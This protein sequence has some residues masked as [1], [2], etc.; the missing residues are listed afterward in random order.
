[1]KGLQHRTIPGDLQH[2]G[3][4][5]QAL[6]ELLEPPSVKDLR[7]GVNQ[8]PLD[9]IGQIDVPSQERV[10]TVLRGVQAD[11]GFV[12]ERWDA[13]QEYV[14]EARG[15]P[16]GHP[17]NRY[18]T[19]I[20]TANFRRAEDIFQLSGNLGMHE[21]VALHEVELS[22]LILSGPLPPPKGRMVDVLKVCG[23]RPF[24]LGL[25]EDCLTAFGDLYSSADD[26]HRPP[27]LGLLGKQ[28]FDE[29]SICNRVI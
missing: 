2:H 27:V 25:D 19:D 16:E 15:E 3:A 10:N 18:W 9:R 12:E 26:R 29:S 21:D 23:I 24:G 4:G 7:A 6:G 17:P 20:K 1:M 28:P 5:S 14:L 13:L 8:F 11:G 22:V